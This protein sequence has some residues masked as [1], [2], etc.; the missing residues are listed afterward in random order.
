[1]VKSESKALYDVLKDITSS[2]KLEGYSYLR[3]DFMNIKQDDQSRVAIE[4]Y[5]DETDKKFNKRLSNQ[6]N[7]KEQSTAR[8]AF[9]RKNTVD[10]KDV[11]EIVR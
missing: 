4:K 2:T 5:M 9:L 11:N 10:V 1:M 7:L 3:E 6:I 8:G